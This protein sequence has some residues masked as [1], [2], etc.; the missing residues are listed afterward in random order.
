[1]K[2]QETSIPGVTLLTPPRYEDSRGVFRPVFAKRLHITEGISQNW[3]EMNV[4]ETKPNCIRGL[5]FQ[6]P[7]PQAKL[8]TVISGEIWDVVVDLRKGENFGR[9]EAFEI[10][11]NRDETPSQIYLPEGVAHG[12]ATPAGPATIS[13]L[14]GSSWNPES[15]QVLAWDDPQLAIPWPVKSPALSPRDQ[16]GLTLQSL[17]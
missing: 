13:Y 6:D 12:L 14:V 9:W 7:H 16:Q 10:S 1:M 15:E 2:T 11:A 5:H 8:I 3:A 4:S 17:R